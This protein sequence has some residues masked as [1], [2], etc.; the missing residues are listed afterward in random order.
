M[1]PIYDLQSR[2]THRHARLIG[3]QTTLS[4][5]QQVAPEFELIQLNLLQTS[6]QLALNMLFQGVE[7]VEPNIPSAAMKVQQNRHQF[8]KPPFYLPFRLCRGR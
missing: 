1:Q 2:A 3:K 6:N 7:D 8:F 4:S 5:L